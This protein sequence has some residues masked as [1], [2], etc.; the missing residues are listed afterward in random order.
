[1]RWIQKY[2]KETKTSTFVPADE[3]A[4]RKDGGVAIHGPIEPFRSPID[5]TVI[6]DRKQLREHCR[7]HGVVPAQ[8]FS[9]DHYEEAA[10]KRAD[11]FTGRRSKEES[12]QIKQ[13]MW[14]LLQRQERGL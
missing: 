3:E 4:I 10:K 8:E 12:L 1:M 13:Q 2:D 6:S 11:L 7:R 14:E 5:G 9:A